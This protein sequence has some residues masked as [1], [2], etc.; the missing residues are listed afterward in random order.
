MTE[1][2]TTKQILVTDD[3]PLFLKGIVNLLTNE[4][5]LKLAG[6]AKNGVE[7]LALLKETPADLLITDVSMP[8][9]D[10]IA[11]SQKVKQLYPQTK[12]LVLSMHCDHSTL[13][14]LMECG[15]NGF[16]S[17]HA[18]SP[19]LLQAIRT[20]LK[21]GR[22]FDDEVKEAFFSSS[23]PVETEA[24]ALPELTSREK[25]ILNLLAQEYT[26]HQIAEKLFI[27]QHTVE[28]HRKNMLRKLDVR[29]TVG[30]VRQ[31]A[32]AGLLEKD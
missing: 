3:H 26:A 2:N 8:D 5:Q 11:L 17:K 22:F 4:K 24:N 18:E 30:L 31:A 32:E 13:M 12:I 10:G 6:V 9:M 7:A 14:K 21:G 25:E 27:S 29:T 28:T 19:E 20:V 15:I 16:L 1:H 23:A